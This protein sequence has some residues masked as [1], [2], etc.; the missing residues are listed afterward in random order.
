VLARFGG[1][2]RTD[3]RFGAQQHTTAMTSVGAA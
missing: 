1:G 2:D 3:V